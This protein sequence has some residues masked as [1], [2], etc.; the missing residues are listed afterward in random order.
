MTFVTEML[1]DNT[2]EGKYEWREALKGFVEAIRAKWLFSP[3]G[4][5][6][7]GSWDADTDRWDGEDGFRDVRVAPLLLLC[8]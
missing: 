6:R 5:E 3:Q 1:L 8:P 2:R 4:D 7:E